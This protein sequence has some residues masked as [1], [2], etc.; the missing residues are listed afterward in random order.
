MNAA[1]P[2]YIDI[3]AV[4]NNSFLAH[5]QDKGTGLSIL[6]VVT[7]DSLA[8][9]STVVETDTT[10]K[11][12]TVTT[13]NQDTGLFVGISQAYSS[14]ASF[15]TAGQVDAATSVVNLGTP[16]LYGCYQYT[17][18]N[19]YLTRLSDTSFAITHY[20]S[21][22]SYVTLSVNTQYGRVNPTTKLVSLGPML[23]YVNGT[24]APNAYHNIVGLTAFQYLVMY[25]T[26]TVSLTVVKVTVDP[27]TFALTASDHYT[28]QDAK[29]DYNSYFQATR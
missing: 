25:M 8:D 23:P 6:K 29:L 2:K 14:F 21:D 27:T 18:V 9:I 19:P 22:A 7:M 20:C 26:P 28:I 13:L 4:F 24:Y 11:F 3:D 10:A 12:Y 5:Y 16:Q 1:C 15:V 17:T